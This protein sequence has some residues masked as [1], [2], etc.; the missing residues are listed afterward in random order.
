MLMHE[1]GF[2]SFTL[3]DESFSVFKQSATRSP[4][5]FSKNNIGDYPHHDDNDV[6]WQQYPAYCNSFYIPYYVCPS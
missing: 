4:V 1:V 2:F 6:Y 5:V 3:R